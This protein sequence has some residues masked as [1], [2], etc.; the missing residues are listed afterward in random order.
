VLTPALTIAGMLW[1]RHRRGLSLV[2]AWL[3]GVC[4]FYQL[5]P[6]GVPAPPVS[7]TASVPFAVTFF[8]LLAVFALGFEA[9]VTAPRS[10]YPPRMFT[11][12]VP[13]AVLVWVPMLCGTA[14]VAFVWLALVGFVYGRDWAD[15]PVW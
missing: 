4:L 14:A 6:A 8:Y 15:R 3:V 1:R 11:L 5:L 13:T 12:P 2:L 10:G 9:D 7:A